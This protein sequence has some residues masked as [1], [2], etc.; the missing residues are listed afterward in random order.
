MFVTVC[1]YF[2]FLRIFKKIKN[3]NKNKGLFFEFNPQRLFKFCGFFEKYNMIN[4]YLKFNYL[5]LFFL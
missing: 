4:F 1:V 2:F 3:T 5:F